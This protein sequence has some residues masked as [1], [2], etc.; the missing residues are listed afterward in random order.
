MKISILNKYSNVCNN[1]RILGRIPFVGNKS[2]S[3]GED[4]GTTFNAKLVS[5]INASIDIHEL[6]YR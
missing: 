5:A 2:I 1:I 4:L 6:H 3:T